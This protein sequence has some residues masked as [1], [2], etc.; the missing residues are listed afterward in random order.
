[1]DNS[2]G[3]EYQIIISDTYYYNWKY[4]DTAC[5]ADGNRLNLIHIA[6]DLD[7]NRKFTGCE[8]KEVVGLNVTRGYLENHAETGLTIKVSGKDGEL[9]FSLPRGYIRG[10]LD[11]AK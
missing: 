6:R 7:C 1:M 4:Y 8:L 10:F 5:D 11:V 2:E 3:G 9:I